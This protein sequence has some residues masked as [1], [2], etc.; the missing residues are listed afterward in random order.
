MERY[1][2]TVRN[3]GSGEVVYET[4]TSRMIEEHQRDYPKE[5]PEIDLKDLLHLVGEVANAGVE[6]WQ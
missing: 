2:V 5:T 3:E 4:S 6:H 1:I